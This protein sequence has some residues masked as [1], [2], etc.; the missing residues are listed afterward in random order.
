M[1]VDFAD[2]DRDGYDEIF[3]AD[4]LSREHVRRQV[5]VEE[6]KFEQQ[7]GRIESR[8]QYSRNTLFWNR[9]DGTYAEIAA[10]SGIE[11]SEWSWTPIFMDVDLDG[12]EDLLVTTGHARDARDIDV[13]RRIDALKSQRRMSRL[14]E[15]SLR[16]MFPKLDTP[17]VAFHN[18]GNLTFEE[19]GAAW[20]FDSRQVSH[21][22]CLA[23]L[24]ND[25]DLDVAVNCLNAG[26]LVYRND[27]PAPRIGVRLR[28]L[29]P[30]TQ[31]IGAKIRILNGAVALQSQEIICGGR[32][33]SD[34]DPLRV[35]AAGSVTNELT[36]DV[37]W[38][39]GGRSRIEQAKPNRIYEIEE[40]RALR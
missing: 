16:K 13:A 10:Y 31:G 38:R 19:V 9:R 39:S 25:G 21:G 12:F 34:D 6:H 27:S 24:D 11:A 30:N 22:M 18:R 35:F 14:E 36:I 40:P 3:V 15:L 23:D 20:G 32:Y 2:L 29:P 7:V 33:L 4:M 5:Q 1:G 28:G 37:N 26:A 8:P 17:N